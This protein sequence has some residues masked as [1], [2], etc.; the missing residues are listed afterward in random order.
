MEIIDGLLRLGWGGK[1]G[2]CEA[3]WHVYAG[4]ELAGGIYRTPD[5]TYHPAVWLGEG[6]GYDQLPECGT[7]GAAH[8]AV[9]AEAA[10]RM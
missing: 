2:G 1:G 8:Q 5:G 10:R 9:L 4:G 3:A 7:L 6:T